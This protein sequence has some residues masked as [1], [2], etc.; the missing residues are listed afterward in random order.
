MWPADRADFD[1]HW[2]T[3]QADLRIDPPVRAYLDGLIRLRY[4]PASLGSPLAPLNRFLT[5]GLLPAPFRDL[6][7]LRWTERDEPR[8]GSLMRAVAAANRLLPGPV[9]RL[10]FNV[11]LL[12]LRARV[13]V[14]REPAHP[15]EWR[16]GRFKIINGAAAG[17]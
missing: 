3:A 2:Q 11:L 13:R 7:R 8:F 14:R 12:E 17:G 6:M 15:P 9:R 1:R 16:H 10:P 5:T 4:L